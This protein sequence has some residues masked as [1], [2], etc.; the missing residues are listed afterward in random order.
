MSEFIGNDG[1]TTLSWKDYLKRGNDLRKNK[2]LTAGQIKELLGKPVIDGQVIEITT[3]GPGA[4]KKRSP[5]GPSAARR[6]A[7]KNIYKSVDNLPPEM[8]NW[9]QRMEAAGKV[10]EGKSLQGF[11]DDHKIK[12]KALLEQIEGLKRLGFIDDETGKS[13]ID[14]GHLLA[15]G[16]EQEVNT[17]LRRKGTHGSHHADARVPELSDVN[18][19]KA[20]LGD[21][22]PL[23]ARRAGIID[24]DLE[25]LTQYLTDD[26]GVGTTPTQA[27]KQRI[28]QGANPD[29]AIAKQIE[30]EEF[31]KQRQGYQH[32]LRDQV[33]G[34]LSS[35]VAKNISNA[36]S[37]TRRAD[38][39][40]Q[41]ATG[42]G[43]GNL[44]QA[45]A[46][47]AGL[48]VTEALQSPASQKAISKQIAKIAAKR[49]GKS[50]LKLIPGLDILISGKEA[51][52]YLA[53]GKFDQAGIAALSGAI[54]WIP[55]IGDG[56][57]AALDLTNT[58]IDI[59]RLD[60]S[61][62][63]DTNTKS[64]SK[65]KSKTKTPD[66]KALRIIKSVT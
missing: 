21:I 40:A 2:N 42:I 12:E 44:V 53:Q 23:D 58:G 10:P 61:G 65:S 31:V 1:I 41:T 26:T 20:H 37:K 28:A 45:G 25:A 32:L 54:G 9:F 39:I 6:S 22:D 47:A 52:D 56:A 59:A 18:Q 35:K 5:R 48:T 11:I 7:K 64:K 34:I 63:S 24:S 33:N 62:A 15:L 8:T 4:I 66:N 38:L 16:S 17:P 49:G 14:D 29:Q 19:G 60:L 36:A 13:L 3:M 46:G 50:A 55:V 30:L 57:S 27:T 43:T 51:Y